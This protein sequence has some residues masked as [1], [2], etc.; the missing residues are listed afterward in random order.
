[1]TD[2]LNGDFL[3]E[4]YKSTMVNSSILEV[5]REHLGYQY[6]PDKH[7][8]KL[9][10]T[11]LSHYNVNNRPPTIGLL[12]QILS[13]DADQ[14][15]MLSD[16]KS[17]GMPNID[18]LLSQ[19]EE[20]IKTAKFTVMYDEL[21][22]TF[23][24]GDRKEAF[25]QLKKHSDDLHNFSIKSQYFD[26]VFEGFTNRQKD[27][28]VTAANPTLVENNFKIPFGIPEL[29]FLTRGGMSNTDT[30]CFLAQSG[31]GKS[32]VLRHIGVN[33]ARLGYRVAHF[34]FEGSKEECLR[35]YDAT[36]TGVLTHSLEQGIV[37]DSQRKRIDKTI[38]DM[39]NGIGGE[40]YVEA[41]EQFGTA[42]MMDVRNSVIEL[43]KL[44]GK[45]HLVLIDYLEKSDPGD[46]R[47]YAVDQEKQ[48]REAIAQKMKNIAVELNTRVATATQAQGIDKKLLDNPEFVMDRYNT[49][50]G[51]N[52]LDSFSFYLTMNQTDDEKDKGIM[53][54]FNDKLRNYPSK[55]TCFIAQDYENNK[56]CDQ[57]K[58]RAKYFKTTS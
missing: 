52:L 37:T 34:Q 1:M 35:A 49:S 48:R 46:G 55:Q 23:K 54:L 33:A 28:D 3:L 10:K 31:V 12:G 18:D 44:H 5:A 30:A 24:K 15:S 13:G 20:Y 16:I 53:R 8:K 11:I 58:T 26:K 42:S 47:K 36:W 57:K 39:K 2:K 27:R 17:C 45:M 41:F 43:E 6:L 29:D 21:Y 40:I 14:L 32:R 4:F 56:F 19:L 9:W 50:M 38:L 25:K 22:E 51:K 7:H